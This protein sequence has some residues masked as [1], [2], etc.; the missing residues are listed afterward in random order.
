MEEDIQGFGDYLAI[1]IKRKKL[2]IVTALIILVLSLALAFGL[3]SVY[4]SEAIIL[5]EQQE[6]PPDLVRSTVTSY[7]GERIQVINQR[8]MTTK[9]LSRIIDEYELFGEE[10]KNTSI[11]VLAE[12]MREDIGLEMISAKVL[13]RSGRSTTATIAFK[14]AFQ[15]KNPRKAQQVANEMVTLYLDENLKSRTASA[16][17]TSG[18]LTTESDKL[19]QIVSEYETKLAAFKEENI[20]NLPGLQTLNI[21]LMERVEREIKDASLQ[22][23]D[24]EGRIT[25]MH[26]ELSQIE[27]GSISGDNDQ[28]ILSPAERLQALRTEFITLST[29]YASTHPD[30][31]KMRREIKALESE[32]G[33][34]V[35]IAGLRRSLEDMKVEM[36]TLQGNYS[37]QHP[38][39][40]KLQHKIDAAEVELDRA[41]GERESGKASG[42][43]TQIDNPA[44]IRMESQ[45]KVSEGE[46]AS[47]KKSREELKQK[48]VEFEER[49]LQSPQIELQYREL[50]RGYANAS[51]RYQEIKEKQ[52]EAGLAET[53]EREKKGERFSLIEPPVL[54]EK[55]SKPNRMAILFLGF[56]LSLVGGVGS[57]AVVEGLSD[58]IT[59]MNELVSIT[60]T[61]PLIVVPYIE[62]ESEKLRYAEIKRKLIIAAIVAI[63]IVIVLF[64]FIVK[65]LDVTWFM[66]LRRLGLS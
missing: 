57:V 36:D 37:Q 52:L 46:L 66:L 29:R 33:S 54:P 16:V 17:E 58:G 48:L 34:S 32:V 59:N 20:D 35:D 42:E 38:D 15:H 25:Y 1:L 60:G 13:D 6:I 11:A 62:I 5:I 24:L 51:A 65:P 9:N 43:S 53:L 22:I 31:K 44:Y 47:L 10:R 30:I 18:C 64:H 2:F 14:L 3:P 55:P 39:V 8:V 7:A 40:K 63:P 27:A 28:R 49:M 50:T 41:V 56:I 45:I 19:E 26:S 4:R 23:R 21:Q 61:A 12:G